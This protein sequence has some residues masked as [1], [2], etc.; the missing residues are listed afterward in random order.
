[1]AA[2]RP[3]PDSDR[4]YTFVL[5]LWLETDGDREGEWRGE[6]RDVTTSSRVAFRHLEGLTGALRELGLEGS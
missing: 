4:S 5:R 3:R 2:E 6:V 1:M